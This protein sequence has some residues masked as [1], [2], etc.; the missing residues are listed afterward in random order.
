MKHPLFSLVAFIKKAM[1][2]HYT[3]VP[4]L[5]SEGGRFHQ[6]K[7]SPVDFDDAIPLSTV[8]HSRSRF[9]HRERQTERQGL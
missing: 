5:V 6:V 7:R 9:L 8:S 1:I 3:M 4:Y 2:H